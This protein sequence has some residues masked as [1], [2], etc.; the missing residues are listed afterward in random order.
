LTRGSRPARRSEVFIASSDSEP[1]AVIGAEP[2]IGETVLAIVVNPARRGEGIGT[3]TLEALAEL[4]QYQASRL[5]CEI[6]SDNVAA[7]LAAAHAG[8]SEGDPDTDG[9][10]TFARVPVEADR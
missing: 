3:S 6:A 4:A 5:T 2:T 10:I 9:Y 7:R 8:F 1:V